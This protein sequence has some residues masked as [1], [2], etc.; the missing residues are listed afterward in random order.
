MSVINYTPVSKPFLMTGVILSFIGTMI[1]SIWMLNLFGVSMP[2]QITPIF[3][4]HRIFQLNGFVTLMIMGVGYMIIPRMRN[5]LTP[6]NRLAK[7]SYLFV[8][9]SISVDFASGVLSGDYSTIATILRLIGVSIFGG[10][11]FYMLRI[12]PKLLKESDYFAAVSIVLLIASQILSLFG[13]QQNILI[14]KQMWLFFPILMIFAIQ[15]KTLPS[16]LGFI[17]PKRKLVIASIV[18]AI[19]S[20][21]LGITTAIA[22]STLDVAFNLSLIA[23]VSCFAISLYIYGGFDNTEIL[24]LITGEK[25]KRY[26]TIILHTRIAYGFLLAGLILGTIHAMHVTNFALYDLTIHYTSIGFIGVTIMLYLPLMIPPILE[27]PVRFLDFNHIPLILVLS[28]LAIRTVGDVI[29]SLHTQSAL[30]FGI[31]GFV[32]L[33]GMLLFV[34][35][36]HRAMKNT[37]SQ[38]SIV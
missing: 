31:S 2:N 37:D 9:S 23:L 1:G 10:L 6:S 21:T 24:K 30:V 17:R 14:Q 35:M 12:A 19:V 16:F 8:I 28:G 29:L 25:K 7:V 11:M 18:L 4:M 13:M 5:E 15:Y 32:I 38:L 20:G 36:V 22:P 27:K 34:R 33:A 3:Q 26:H